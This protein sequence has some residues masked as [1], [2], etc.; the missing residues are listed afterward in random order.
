MK[1]NPCVRKLDREY[2]PVQISRAIKKFSQ[3]FI[4][5]KN[6]EN[7]IDIVEV[8]LARED[9]N[10]DRTYKESEKEV[11]KRGQHFKDTLKIEEEKVK[12]LESSLLF[13]KPTNSRT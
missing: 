8:T 7:N 4:F 1:K 11:M 13:Q 5:W 6:G 9:S 12:S 10:S 2:K 3:V